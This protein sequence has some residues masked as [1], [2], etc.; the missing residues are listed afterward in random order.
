MQCSPTSCIES[1]ESRQLLSVAVTLTNS[2]LDLRG[3]GAD[4]VILGAYGGGR[5]DLLVN[6]SLKRFTTTQ[7]K[8]VNVD[9]GGGNDTV[10][11][12]GQF[13]LPGNIALGDGNDFCWG[14]GRENLIRGG[15]GNDTINA[16]AGN[17]TVYGDAGNDELEG[18]EGDDVVYGGAGNDKLAGFTGNNQLF[19]EDGDDWLY[20]V[21]QGRGVLD[22]GAGYD[23][24]Q[25][26]PAT[27]TLKNIEKVHM[28]LK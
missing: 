9:S 4:D 23:R 11:F 10:W 22:G 15:N 16:S 21:P 5:V 25:Y 17:D 24:V 7:V 12:G 3:N 26:A 13:W 2:T 8:R 28:I 20:G 14:T 6:G 19:G 1:L 27:W 18:A